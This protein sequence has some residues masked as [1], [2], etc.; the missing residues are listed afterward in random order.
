MT[1]LMKACLSKSVGFIAN[2]SAGSIQ[3]KEFSEYY[4]DTVGAFLDEYKIS[5]TITICESY[6]GQALIALNASIQEKT[7][8]KALS[9]CLGKNVSLV[10]ASFT[11]LRADRPSWSPTPRPTPRPTQT[12]RPSWSP[13][14]RPTPLPTQTARPSWDPTQKPTQTATPRPTPFIEHGKNY[15]DT[16]IFRSTN[17]MH[18]G[19]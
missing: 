11:L 15:C 1:A 12:A 17:A 4:S 3:L 8:D 6:R 7:Y 9:E 10:A 13:T 5:G 16:V 19:S 2:V 18:S 14:P